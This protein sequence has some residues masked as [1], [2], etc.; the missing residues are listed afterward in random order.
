M[1]EH[2]GAYLS[3]PEG[4]KAFKR[5]F[6]AYVVKKPMGWMYSTI[7][8]GH[9]SLGGLLS[10]KA[11]ENIDLASS[12]FADATNEIT[13]KLSENLNTMVPG[14]PFTTTPVRYDPITRTWSGGEV[15]SQPIKL[16]VKYIN[17]DGTP[18]LWK[19]KPLGK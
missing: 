5:L 18:L 9:E 13:D 14:D 6:T 16:G 3:S 11:A 17:P 15:I 19:E 12:G 10:N 1:G 8:A 4:S 2:A 7:G